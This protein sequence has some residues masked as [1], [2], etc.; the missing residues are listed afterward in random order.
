M[1]AKFLLTMQLKKQGAVKGSSTR[2]EG[3]LD[4]SKGVECHAFTYSVEPPVNSNPGLPVGK[5]QHGS[6]SLDHSASIIGHGFDYGVTAPLDSNPGKPVG[7]RQHG[8][9][10][11]RKEVD[12]ASPKLLRA[13]T[14]NETFTNATLQFNKGISAGKLSLYYTIELINGVI[15][16]MRPARGEGGKRCEDVILR[17]E[18]LF[19]R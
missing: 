10:V 13:L 14:T 18:S 9:I 17:Y 2:K 16:G 5:R 4:F 8:L 11:I 15:C 3:D 19:Q 6:G 7:R 12:G 1:G